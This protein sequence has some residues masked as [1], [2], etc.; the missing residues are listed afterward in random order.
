MSRNHRRE[1]REEAEVGHSSE[2]CCTVQGSSDMGLEVVAFEGAAMVID[3]G[4]G[5]LIEGNCIGDASI[6]GWVR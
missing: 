1:V 2:E 6:G 5:L 4:R 3:M